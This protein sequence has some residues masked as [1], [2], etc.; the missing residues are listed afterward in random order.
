MVFDGKNLTHD[1]QIEK[2]L[3]GTILLDPGQIDACAALVPDDFYLE[4]HKAIFTALRALHEA[5]DDFD[6]LTLINKLREAGRLDSVGG[7]GYLIDLTDLI[8][9]KN[10]V[11]P[12]L[13]IIKEKSR[14]RRIDSICAEATRRIEIGDE[15]DGILGDLMTLAG[16]EQLG[17]NVVKFHHISELV[18]PHLNEMKNQRLFKGEILGIPS[19][20][21]ALDRMTTGWRDGEL[22]FVGALPGR[23]K[24]SLLVQAMYGAATMDHGVGCISLEMRSGQLLKRLNTLHSNIHSYKFRDA[25]MM[26]EEEYRHA[27]KMGLAMGDLPIWICDQSG[28]NPRQI[29]LLARQMVEKGAKA[30]FVDFVQII[31]EE[32][33]DRREA[34]NRVSAALRD[35]AKQLNKP[36]VVAS[37]LAR[38]D[39]DPNRRPTIQDLRESGNLEQDAHNVILLYRPKD[40]SNGDWSGKDE[41]IVDKQRE[42]M[43]G[44]VPV[45]YDGRTLTYKEREV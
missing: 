37:Q 30:I 12:Y 1:E 19:G 28:L 8:P 33:K 23:G 2:T 27:R 21:D 25:R 45:R 10:R 6:T 35:C 40:K 5:G 13:K 39:S 44:I 20:I 15:A 11:E 42:G 34:I 16:Q 36:F 7:Q 9:R 14:L 4:S 3:L 31:A 41:L 17:A 22:T 38:R 43:T 26:Q 29:T 18:I 32:G 24:T